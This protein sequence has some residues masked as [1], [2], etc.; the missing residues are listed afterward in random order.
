MSLLY[1][2][3]RR[4]E[5]EKGFT[6]I[7]LL[8]VILIIG[9]LAAIA[10]PSFLN[11]KTKANDAQAKEM[12]R[13]AQ[14]AM[15]TYS[16]DHNGSYTGVTVAALKGIEPT[17]SDTSGATFT[18]AATP[19]TGAGAGGSTAGSSYTVTSHSTDG[20]TFSVNR[21]DNGSTDRSCTASASPNSGGC[22]GG[23]W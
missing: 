23:S 3:R 16:T 12:A 9:I 4:A 5:D 14:T 22:V 21:Y 17:L 19:S 1:K 6:L 11:Q 20:N 18:V 13:T 10:I 8:V 7:E 2:A 15:E